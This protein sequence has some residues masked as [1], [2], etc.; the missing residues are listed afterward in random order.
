VGERFDLAIRMGNLPDSSLIAKPLINIERHFYASKQLLKKT[1]T[2]RTLAQLQ[3]MPFIALLTQA[4]GASTLSLKIS[5]SNVPFVP[6]TVIKTNSIGL[7]RELAVAGAG[8]AALPDAMGRNQMVRVLQLHKPQSVQ[9]HFLLPQKQ[10]LPAKTKA[11]IEHVQAH[12]V[13]I[14]L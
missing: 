5:G 12:L 14:K 9:A 1:G 6:R 8:V 11:F 2:P 4:P 13:H 7:V 3:E 10:W